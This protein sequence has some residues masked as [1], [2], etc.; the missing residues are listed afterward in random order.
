[1][2]FW[3][4]KLFGMFVDECLLCNGGMN[5]ACD[6]ESFTNVIRCRC[7]YYNGTYDVSHLLF[8]DVFRSGDVNATSMNDVNSTSSYNVD[9][10]SSYDVNAT[11]S[12]DGNTTSMNDINATNSYNENATSSYNENTSNIYDVNYTNKV[13]LHSA[14]RNVGQ[15]CED[16]AGTS[17]QGKFTAV[18]AADAKSAYRLHCKCNGA[19]EETVLSRYFSTMESMYMS[20]D[21]K[22]SNFG[23]SSNCMASYFLVDRDGVNTS[24]LVDLVGANMDIE[25]PVS[26]VSSHGGVTDMPVDA[27]PSP[28]PSAFFIGPEI[29]PPVNA[30]SHHGDT[31]EYTK[32]FEF[33]DMRHTMV[34]LFTIG[35]VIFISLIFLFIL[36]N[37][38]RA[39]IRIFRLKR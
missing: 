17:M 12:Y 26:T 20:Y 15:F 33:V 23:V 30:E 9:V 39:C 27:T 35:M 4:K 22:M 13:N 5:Y 34:S 32:I 14:N 3:I 19:A 18:C 25:P 36:V 6:I 11:S 37:V 29:R 7:W 2:I 1:M 10:T 8:G 28:T 38:I 16:C 24:R 21:Q 31:G